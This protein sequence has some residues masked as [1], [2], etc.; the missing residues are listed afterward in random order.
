MLILASVQVV[1]R[2]SLDPDR[3]PPIE[4]PGLRGM[5]VR[6]K[7]LTT[8]WDGLPGV[9]YRYEVQRHEVWVTSDIYDI[10]LLIP[11][12]LFVLIN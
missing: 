3:S 5:S 7:G 4:Y 12:S 8:L 11:L 6:P 2:L 1:L 9:I 10:L